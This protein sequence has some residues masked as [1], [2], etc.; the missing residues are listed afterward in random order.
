MTH[1]SDAAN[2]LSL[3]L[4]NHLTSLDNDETLDCLA[5]LA[6]Q[7]NWTIKILCSFQNLF[8][9]LCARW[10][11][12]LDAPTALAACGRVIG[13]VPWLSA[14]IERI[15]TAACAGRN[16]LGEICESQNELT[17]GTSTGTGVILDSLVASYRL[18]A[19]DYSMFETLVTPA[20]FAR[21]TAHR[22]HRV[23]YLSMLLLTMYLHLSDAS[24]EA[25]LRKSTGGESCSG[26]VDGHCIDL[27]FLAL[28][29]R[30][31]LDIWK[32]DIEASRYVELQ[33]NDPIIARIL[34]E[35]NTYSSTVELFGTI[36]PSETIPSQ[37]KP[38]A[39]LL[40]E[41]PTTIENGAA[42]IE[43]MRSSAPILISG[44]AGCGKSLLLNFVAAKSR[45]NMDLVTLHVNAQTD[46][47]SLIGMHVTGDIPG[48][49]KWQPGVLA[50]AMQEG[51]WI[52][53]EDL[54]HAPKEV[55]GV[56]TSI[57]K[58]RELRMPGGNNILK[59]SPSFRFFATC[60]T[61][62]VARNFTKETGPNVHG[63][64]YFRKVK[65]APLPEEELSHILLQRYDKL[66]QMREDILH[67]YTNLKQ[68]EVHLGVS[69]PRF[70]PL[71]PRALF[72]WC[73]RI[74][75][76]RREVAA[77][78]DVVSTSETTFDHIFLDA[79]DCFAGNVGNDSQQKSRY[80]QEIARA[81][82]IDSAR[83]DYVR[84]LRV[85]EFR[86]NVRRS[87][88]FI[89]GRCRLGVDA[90]TRVLSGSFPSA[91]FSL[92]R[93]TRR[94]ME[95]VGCAVQN[96]EPLL[97][98]GETGIGKTSSVQYLAS[99]MGKPLTV[100]NLSQQSETGD[101]IGSFKPVTVRS[102]VMPLKEE[103]DALFSQT[104]SGGKNLAYSEK[105][106]RLIAKAKWKEAVRF[107]KHALQAFQ[108]GD[109]KSLDKISAQP[110]A[111]GRG[112]NKRRKIDDTS[113]WNQFAEKVHALE[114]RLAA[115][116]DGFAFSFVEG[117]LVKAVRSGGWVL[118]DEINLAS[119]DT[120][121]CLSELLEV[122]IES[123]PSIQFNEVASGE[124]VAVHPH[125]RLF[126][127]MNPST[128]FGKKELAPGIRSRF[129]EIFVESPER[130]VESLE[131]I[132]STY[133]FQATPSINE[134]RMSK[135]V[136]ELFL[137]IQYEVRD[138]KLVDGAGSPAHYSLRSLTRALAH[139]KTLTVSCGLRRSL[140][141][142]FCMCFVTI[143]DQNSD[144]HLQQ[145]LRNVLFNGS[146][147]ARKEL[148]KALHLSDPNREF[149][150]VETFVAHPQSQSKT[151]SDVKITHS[152]PKGP[153]APQSV[154]EYVVTPLVARN[155]SNLART[156][157]AGS[158]PVLIQGPTS[159]GKTSMIEYLAKVSGNRLIRINNHEHTDLQ[160]YLGTYVSTR[161]GQLVFQDG[162]LVRALKKGYWVVLD[163]LN[164]APTDVLE[165][166]NRL[167]D[168][169]RELFIPETQERVRPHP[170]FMLFA[171]QNPAGAYGGRK[172]LST[173]FRNRFLELHH[174]DIPVD[175][176]ETILSSRSQLPKS[177]SRQIVKVYSTLSR[178]RQQTRLFEQG[179]FA[180]LRDLFRWALRGATSLQELAE[181]GFM[182][183]AEKTRTLEERAFVKGVIEQDMSRRGVEI[184][185]NER[186]LYERIAK[187]GTHKTQSDVIW[188]KGMQRLY[189]LV[190]T[191]VKH[192]EPV[193]LV[194]ETG[195]GKTRVC[196]LLAESAGRLLSTVNAHQN[197]ET[198][199][200]V[201]AQRPNR[202]R[203]TTANELQRNL[204]QAFKYAGVTFNQGS[205]LHQYKQL[206]N[207]QRRE[208][209]SVLRES[210]ETKLSSMN[211]LFEWHDGCLVQAMKAGNYFLL[212][213]ISLADDSVLERLNSVLDPSRTILLAEKGTSDASI[214]AAPG[215]QFVAT[216][217]P[218]GDYGKRELSAALRNRFTEIWVP[219]MNDLDDACQI[220]REKLCDAAKSFADK[221]VQFSAW[222]NESYRSSKMGIVTLRDLLTWVDFINIIPHDGF[223][224]IYH[225]A[226]LVFLDTLGANPSGGVTT[227]QDIYHERNRCSECLCSIFHL[228]EADYEV[229]DI[230]F[231]DNAEY[232]ELG[233]FRLNKT[234]S[235]LVSDSFNFVARSTRLNAM[236]VLRS[237]QLE[238]PL[239]LEGAPG[240]G[241]TS[242]V[243][244]IASKSGR[245]LVRLNL[246]EQTDLSDLFGSDVPVESG[247]IGT[248][249]WRDAPF[250]T[251][252][253]RGEWVL[254]DEMNLASQSVL[255]GL[256]AC[257][258]HRREVF[259]PELGMTFPRHPQFRIFATQNPHL[260]GSGRKGLPASFVNRFNVIFFEAFDKQDLNSM[261]RF[262]F[263]PAN[264]DAVKQ[265]VDLVSDLAQ[266]C[267]GTSGFGALG[268][269][270]EFNLR[271]ISRI[272]RLRVLAATGELSLSTRDIANMFVGLR[273]RSAADRQV[274]MSLTA[275][276][277][278]PQEVPKSMFYHL[279]EDHLQLGS[280][281]LARLCDLSDSLA[282]CMRMSGPILPILE[283]MMIC[284]QHRWPLLL[285]GH[286]QSGKI[287]AVTSIG[288][289][290]GAQVKAIS[291]STDID[292]SDL[293]GCFDHVDVHQALHR[294]LKEL[295]HASAMVMQR[296]MKSYGMNEAVDI[297]AQLLHFARS[298]HVVSGSI[299][300]AKTLIHE[301]I[302][303]LQALNRSDLASYLKV[304]GKVQSTWAHIEILHKTSAGRFRWRDGPLIDAM[305]KGHWLILEN[306]NLSSPSVLD[307]LNSLLEPEGVLVVS[308]NCDTH[309][310]PRIVKP[311]PDFRIFLT[312]D[313]RYGEISRA[314]RN[315]TVELFLPSTAGQLSL[316]FRAL[317]TRYSQ[318]LQISELTAIENIDPMHLLERLAPNDLELLPHFMDSC[319]QGLL[320]RSSAAKLHEAYELWSLVGEA[321]LN[322]RTSLFGPS[323]H[324][325]KI[326]AEDQP[327]H[328]LVNQPCVLE[329]SKGEGDINPII[330]S[331]RLL[332]I[333]TDV[334]TIDKCLLDREEAL[335][336]HKQ[337]DH[338]VF[339]NF[340][341]ARAILGFVSKSLQLA[342]ELATDH[343][344]S[345]PSVAKVVW[346][347]WSL[348]HLSNS[349]M[350]N[351]DL[352]RAHL[353][354]A[355]HQLSRDRGLNTAMSDDELS[356]FLPEND[357]LKNGQEASM[358]R[359]WTVFRG[360]LMTD[361][362]QVEVVK[363]L[364][365]VTYHVDTMMS[366]TPDLLRDIADLRLSIRD[367][368]SFV[369]SSRSTEVSRIKE[370]HEALCSS[371]A[372][373]QATSRPAAVVHFQSC[374]DL[375]RRMQSL[376]SDS[377]SQSD[378][379]K[380][381]ERELVQVLA[382]QPLQ[383]QIEL[384]S[385]EAT[386]PF[387]Q[388]SQYASAV[389][390]NLAGPAAL[391]ELLV[392]KIPAVTSCKLSEV[393]LMREETQI[394]GRLLA[395]D[396]PRMA[397]FAGSML[398]G[399]L[400]AAMLKVLEAIA[401]LFGKYALDVRSTLSHMNIGAPTRGNAHMQ[402]DWHL[403]NESETHVLDVFMKYL[404]PVLQSL[405]TLPSIAGHANV[406]GKPFVDLGIGCLE[407]Y[408]P[409]EAHDPAL[410]FKLQNDLQESRSQ[411]AQA[412]L[413]SAQVLETSLTG[414]TKTLR[415]MAIEREIYEQEPHASF[416]API[417][418]ADS[419]MENLQ[420]VLQAARI[421]RQRLKDVYVS[422]PQNALSLE[423]MMKDCM[424]LFKMLMQVQIE[425]QDIVKPLI[426]FVQCVKLGLQ[427]D[428]GSRSRSK[429]QT[430]HT[431]SLTATNMTALL[432]LDMQN[433]EDHVIAKDSD[434]L[435]VSLHRLAFFRRMA[436]HA[437][438][439]IGDTI[440]TVVERLYMTYSRLFDEAK[441]NAAKFS[442]I[443]EYRDNRE[444]QEA[445]QEQ[446]LNDLFD[447]EG[448][449]TSQDTIQKLSKAV[450]QACE[451]MFECHEAPSV[452][453]ERLVTEN[454]HAYTSD[455]IRLGSENVHEQTWAWLTRHLDQQQLKLNNPRH[456]QESYNVY[457]DTNVA[458][459]EK[460]LI[461]VQSIRTR[462][463][464]L[465]R[466]WPEH[467]VL[468]SA[469]KY[470]NEIISIPVSEP[471]A[472]NI[473]RAESLYNMIDEW[474]RV[475]SREY[476]VVAEQQALRGL[477]VDWRKLELSTWARLMDM[478]AVRAREEAYSWWFVA[479]ESTIVSMRAFSADSQEGD[480]HIVQILSTLE[481][482]L[483]NATI[484]QFE[485]RLSILKTIHRLI[486]LD[487]T[488]GLVYTK[489]ATGL[490][491]LGNHFSRYRLAIRDAETELRSS[492][493]KQVTDVIKLAS[494]KDTNV[495]ALRQSSKASHNKLVRLIHKFRDGL[496][497]PCTPCFTVTDSRLQLS[498]GQQQVRSQVLGFDSQLLPA[499][500]AIFSAWPSYYQSPGHTARTIR[501]MRSSWEALSTDAAQRLRILVDEVCS[502]AKELRQSTPSVATEE[503]V[504]TVRHLNTRKQRLLA[505][506]L[507]NGKDAGLKT[508]QSVAV[509]HSQKSAADI[510]AH[511]NLAD[512]E[513]L[514]EASQA[515]HCSIDRM[516][517]ARQG[518]IRHSDDLNR[519]DV[520]RGMGQ[521][522]S[523]LH[524]CLQQRAQMNIYHSHLERFES[525]RSKLMR[526]FNARLQCRT[527]SELNPHETDLCYCITN[528]L[529]VVIQVGLHLIESQARLGDLD[530]SPVA[531][532]LTNQLSCFKSL[533]ENFTDR[534][535]LPVNLTSE[536]HDQLHQ[537]VV[538]N[539]RSFRKFLQDLLNSCPVA[540]PTIAQ[541]LTWTEIDQ[542]M[543]HAYDSR[544]IT[545]AQDSA[546]GQAITQTLDQVLASVQDNDGLCKTAKQKSGDESWLMKANT[547]IFDNLKASR[548]EA[549]N[550]SLDNIEASL[551]TCD[552][553]KGPGLVDALSAIGY[554][555]PILSQ[556]EENLRL[557]CHHLRGLHQA[558]TTSLFDLCSLFN[559]VVENG[560]CKPAEKTEAP[561]KTSTKLEEGT[562]L[563]DGEVAEDIS[564]D[565]QSDEDMSELA[566]EKQQSGNENLQDAED[567]LNA[568]ESMDGQQADHDPQE[569][570]DG[571]EAGERD[572]TGQAERENAE[573]LHESGDSGKAAD[574]EQGGDEGIDDGL[575]NV[576]DMERSAVDEKFWE[577]ANEEQNEDGAA[578]NSIDGARRQE[579][580]AGK[581]KNDSNE[582]KGHEDDE[583]DE[584]GKQEN[585]T[586]P[587]E[588]SENSEAP[589]EMHDNDMDP[590]MDK[591]DVL[592]L[593]DELSLGHNMADKEELSDLASD[594]EMDDGAEQ[595]EVDLQQ[596]ENND[597]ALEDEGENGSDND[598]ADDAAMEDEPNVP[599]ESA[600]GGIENADDIT[601]QPFADGLVADDSVGTAQGP[602]QSE[603]Q[604]K[605]RGQDDPEASG[606]EKVP[607][608][609]TERG[610]APSNA[611]ARQSGS[612]SQAEAA[613]TTQGM[614]PESI[615]SRET[616][617]KLGDALKPFQRAR[618]PIREQ[619]SNREDN[620]LQQDIDM[621]N[622]EIEH[623]PNE[624][625][626]A[627]IQALGAATKEQAHPLDSAD[628]EDQVQASEQENGS[629]FPQQ[630]KSEQVDLEPDEGV[631]NA[632][633]NDSMNANTGRHGTVIGQSNS[634]SD[635]EQQPM[636]TSEDA[637]ERLETVSQ[638]FED[639]QIDQAAPSAPQTFSSATTWQQHEAST[640]T[641]ALSL[642]E[643]LRLILAPTQATKLRGDFRSGKR[644]N[645][646]RIIPYIASSYKRDKIWMRRSVP[647]KRSYQIQ[648]AI[649]DSKS[650]GEKRS[651][652]LAFSTLAL[653]AGSLRM[654]EAGEIGVVGFGEDVFVA[655]ELG[656]PFL[657]G[658]GE[659][660]MQNFSFAQ[661]Q[662]DV[663]K[664]VEKSIDLFRDARL[665]AHGS[666]SDLWQLQ[667][668]ISDGYFSD[669]RE[670]RRLLMQA[671]EE[672]IMFVFLV[673]DSMDESG[674]AKG[675]GKK[676]QS[677]LDLME[678]EIVQ[679][680]PE[681]EGEQPQ[682]R[683]VKRRYID[684]FPFKYFLL[685]RDVKDLPNVLGTALRQ[686]FA[687][688]VES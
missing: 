218:A 200:F 65:F 442:S 644:L 462:L 330:T 650:M 30:R 4:R 319:K 672:R 653:V 262:S 418:P 41:T 345:L 187:E 455:H 46:A 103:F 228:N 393:S 99:V 265:T 329:M 366:S 608:E 671:Y 553:K 590:H 317:E 632:Q 44:P 58:R 535:P 183:L 191:A 507:R 87:S 547:L 208:V 478:Q 109:T 177:W 545:R 219:P 202:S 440:L 359:M 445:A 634:P 483:R 321:W 574:A 677:I 526:A 354:L 497:Q 298:T 100:L 320:S 443:F 270:W 637:Q 577:Q 268:R 413:N 127:A 626:I 558:S 186:S 361:D 382:G 119:S 386:G 596:Y 484:G 264:P 301:V 663:R 259:I 309:G 312:T 620:A 144:A 287:E 648:L 396:I 603:R 426:G 123:E 282:P 376:S 356:A 275:E 521:L 434:S 335:A 556:Y 51:S 325:K 92:N 42:L 336:Q 250:L 557:H 405:K 295:D 500:P 294:S 281:N 304:L 433:Y 546:I 36:W 352:M 57:L 73:E 566:A 47:K 572:A 26:D 401:P 524:L 502:S 499:L 615:A 510:F 343:S 203:E 302:N 166:L 614:S 130:D 522:E 416:Q 387:Q 607:D 571:D 318:I 98:V 654:L 72:K 279:S 178:Q 381:H 227:D 154:D 452:E 451:H 554:T 333:L 189:S 474:S 641:L 638:D 290:V 267:G 658:S 457:T 385:F 606:D 150:Q 322:M 149:M 83:R 616:I 421:L 161:N 291:M 657:S 1:T 104:F 473:T 619:A 167:L 529:P 609:Q 647:S 310:D 82:Q 334:G 198:S 419:S 458:E 629:A 353:R 551:Q 211:M 667:F 592:D 220:V 601:A 575:G 469:I 84:T 16:I 175:E 253:K 68:A 105:L 621:A 6:A 170:N 34:A 504:A 11:R 63:M 135:A 80:A 269:P 681:E 370:S 122:S 403:P 490:E 417:R 633:V 38:Q 542:S 407:L 90:N 645:M 350:A 492:V 388:L 110:G 339:Q 233:G 389:G 563:G 165:A 324:L 341:L 93:H 495:H 589:A 94:T 45:P 209:P 543:M 406:Q 328:P 555:L 313:P 25:L 593:P 427:I 155:L 532:Y 148:S 133:L 485:T 399:K 242:L 486:N 74:T 613:E 79:L 239:L 491:N 327:L 372:K 243:C 531:T 544:Q 157:S 395:R 206:D 153:N 293:I 564:K 14:H 687:E 666:A 430:D 168:E 454:R 568:D 61:S 548:I 470:C 604:G 508:I 594:E 539:Y 591:G 562:G 131:D 139:A 164:L 156:L 307:R 584:A 448:V 363:Q 284:I 326:S 246:S 117:E 95:Q 549:I 224:R 530:L 21:L 140:Y 425:Y 565:I 102:V 71:S 673:L 460:F 266:R 342:S 226:H 646:K 374:F 128:D 514:D 567:A 174:A 649:D 541:L 482:L 24:S 193:L 162:L 152:L 595:G 88:D 9:E 7:P 141:E 371:N 138:G 489:L 241:K 684:T 29:E 397:G 197:L 364:Q 449:S 678:M 97:L 173:A 447:V 114:Q 278:G 476:S 78:K 373:H 494:W 107:W 444:M 308:E 188:T 636:D 536:V 428:L 106:G 8:A 108:K 85:P 509:L 86:K 682:R 488:K 480:A 597:D 214:T 247:E 642:T 91:S 618:R 288:R 587:D 380:H 249:S 337:E 344:S 625:S 101:M 311:H 31:R 305:E 222:F 583:P 456:S 234:G 501:V 217:N 436:A 431:H 402:E 332:D 229:N 283:S 238:K 624:Q 635:H 680:P 464:S 39:N 377:L 143:L 137:Q 628:A 365:Q 49:F 392:H 414:Q 190:H 479:Y 27:R 48:T 360:P 231:T 230:S 446:D 169:N 300:Q 599:D 669:H 261:A 466:S 664:M 465:V 69:G 468:H 331:G 477:I 118:L 357:A 540:R 670:V 32:K 195:T 180:T 240:V 20:V 158:Y 346:L 115:D 10:T 679:E 163:E 515:L 520:S 503:N 519:H 76:R 286:A 659:A 232:L 450:A 537:E 528:W 643:Q 569:A 50:K 391:Q 251:A 511:I 423:G 573:G 656:V 611:N 612:S 19:A 12:L 518:V 257:I 182:L 498:L 409:V 248:F 432:H 255:E 256:N 207:Q 297:V 415:T 3:E 598:K 559:Q 316:P 622:T 263:P 552:P 512:Y 199:D 204:K 475:A 412:K 581:D 192:S 18:L 472:R 493:G 651:A 639:M 348:A 292:T 550:V 40:C 676:A 630:T 280:A 205:A 668:I 674:D 441:T 272:L 517:H 145:L 89:V 347:S 22:D 276:I 289:A 424:R 410:I 582:Q 362:K 125:F 400:K 53:V 254:L 129:T 438:H 306:A 459:S 463:E 252:M 54:D 600:G 277:Y 160:E 576:D 235:A 660:V 623:L 453:L 274:M 323:W 579:Q 602:D 420:E 367:A 640:H 527:A 368:M 196:Q 585:S 411:H 171:T 225:G 62:T 378:R 570:E 52:L 181:S 435:I 236:R 408:I 586:D 126:A 506:T 675:K 146:Q 561:G 533:Q 75:L 560:F 481:T 64:H 212:D 159:A 134:S 213:E 627:D 28:F 404:K 338:F 210:I 351:R 523:L 124:R 35:K 112:P 538:E 136:A 383:D 525:T 437:G 315:R 185:I 37:D 56:F 15:L 655:H 142:G 151:T 176:L 2:H 223:A 429:L 384:G 422:Q 5:K 17:D 172:Q 610:D 33:A 132:V 23:R 355:R 43:A 221:L 471:V 661:G 665:K 120:L 216:M 631:E 394:L 70:R 534:A 605:G 580:A 683:V 116:N 487:H 258:D 244:A 686:W 439:R 688:V 77:R 496:A 349:Q 617:R 390:T 179:G 314:M 461:I 13:A 237:L 121:E 685:V 358:E 60:Q 299:L 398:T 369:Y 662:T 55:M 516:T 59:A 260:Q 96:R 340:T 505:D 273:F 303:R 111:D 588:N 215:F 245:D 184:K 147:N 285:V 375:I 379:R 67:V 467:A 194:G 81:L 296:D 201:G 652:E 578:Q 513:W 113:A 271:D 66:S